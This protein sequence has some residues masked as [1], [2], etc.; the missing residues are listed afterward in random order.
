MRRIGRGRRAVDGR[1]AV[2]AGEAVVD[3]AMMGL[4]RP[5][6]Q[7]NVA[8]R[9]V[10]RQLPIV[11]GDRRR[12]HVRRSAFVDLLQIQAV[13]DD[14]L[15]LEIADQPVRRARRHQVEQEEDDVEDALASWITSRSK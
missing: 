14:G 12:G 6:D 4:V 15:F 10:G 8:Q 5:H 3:V 13:A 9:R 7:N 2:T 11:D 1:A